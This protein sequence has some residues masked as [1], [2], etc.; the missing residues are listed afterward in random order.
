MDAGALT[1]DRVTNMELQPLVPVLPIF[2][3]RQ[4]K[5]EDYTFSLGEVT[6]PAI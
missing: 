4:G 2:S 3:G 1:T 5:Y 6:S